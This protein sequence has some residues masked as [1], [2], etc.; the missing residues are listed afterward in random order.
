MMTEH[1]V[2][3]VGVSMGALVRHMSER[4]AVVVEGREKSMRLSLLATED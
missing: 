4:T 3:A 2:I 1:Q